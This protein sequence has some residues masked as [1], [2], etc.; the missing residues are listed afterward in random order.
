MSTIVGF[1][2]LVFAGGAALAVTFGP[3]FYAVSEVDYFG[4]LRWLGVWCWTL[5]WLGFFIGCIALYAQHHPDRGANACA[6][7][8][9]RWSIVGHHAQVVGKV[10]TEANDYGCVREPQ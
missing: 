2:L 3:L 6:D 9:G 7:S 5:L 4:W 8:G 1:V 10:V